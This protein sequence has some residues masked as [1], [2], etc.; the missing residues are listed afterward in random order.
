[1]V[2]V[3]GLLGWCCA[4]KALLRL[5][6]VKRYF[7]CCCCSDDASSPSYAVLSKVLWVPQ[8]ALARLRLGRRHGGRC[9]LFEVAPK[10]A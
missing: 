9:N 1:L 6:Y 5:T 7:C 2:D 8:A 4:S 3:Q 10:A